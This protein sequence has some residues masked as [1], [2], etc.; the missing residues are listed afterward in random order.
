MG[1]YLFHFAASQGFVD[2]NKRTAAACMLIFLSLNGYQL[3]ASPNE[4]YDLTI[5]AATGS[6]GKKQIAS[7]INN[8]LVPQA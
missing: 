2:G 3:N 8:R 5:A 1:A 6:M 4:V 7:W